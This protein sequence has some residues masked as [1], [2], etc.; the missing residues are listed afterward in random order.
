MT[1]VDVTETTSTTPPAAP[2]QSAGTVD[3][4]SRNTLPA[5]ELG[6]RIGRIPVTKV[7]PVIEGGAYAGRDTTP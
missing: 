7:S 4:A 1:D 2:E 5:A 6:T 3:A